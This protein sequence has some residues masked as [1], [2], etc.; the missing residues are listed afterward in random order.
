MNIK[1]LLTTIEKRNPWTMI[2]GK[3]KLIEII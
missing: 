1:Q 2:K 3:E